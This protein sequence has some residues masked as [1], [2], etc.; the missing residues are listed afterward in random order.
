MADDCIFCRIAKGEIP[1]TKVAETDQALAFRDLNPQAPV[2][3]LVIPKI[4]I[5]SM[6]ETDDPALLGS[7]LHLVAQVAKSEG[8]APQ[9]YRTVLNTGQNGGQ[10]V[11]HLHAHLLGGRHMAWPPG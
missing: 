2:H 9:G 3:I 1:A 6:A 11:N 5:A 4:H 8:L 7:V 10:T